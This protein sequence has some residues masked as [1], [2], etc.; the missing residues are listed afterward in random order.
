[1]RANRVG[2]GATGPWFDTEETNDRHVILGHHS[3]AGCLSDRL[4]LSFLN[5]GCQM[6]PQM[7]ACSMKSRLSILPRQLN[8]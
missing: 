5:Q 2:G 6:R 3:S 8:Y 1:M 7:E 4:L